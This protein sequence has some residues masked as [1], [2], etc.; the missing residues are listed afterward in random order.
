[1]S[2][3]TKILILLPNL[4]ICAELLPTKKPH[5]YSIATL[6][7]HSLEVMQKGGFNI[8]ALEKIFST[9]EKDGSYHLILSDSLFTQTIQT[10]NAESDSA[11]K[12]EIKS[13]ILPALDLSTNTHFL[14]PTVL[15]QHKG[16]TRVQLTA[17][18]K[19]LLLP[20]R[21]IA[22]KHSIDL[23]SLT[24]LSW[25]IKSMIT[26][27]PSVSVIELEGIL[28]IAQ[29]YIGVENC[30]SFNHLELK[31]AGAL[32]S[33]FKKSEPSTMSVYAISSAEVASNL[34][35]LIKLELPL[36]KMNEATQASESDEVTTCLLETIA[37]TISITDFPVP[38]LQLPKATGLEIKEYLAVNSA[39]D[40]SFKNS[41]TINQAVNDI[42]ENK[43]EIMPA[44]AN[45]DSKKEMEVVQNEESAKEEEG[46]KIKTSSSTPVVAPN[47]SE[48]L[49]KPTAVTTSISENLQSSPQNNSIANNEN[50]NSEAQP[51]INTTSIG[52]KL[53]SSSS[54]V[55][56]GIDLTQF[57]GGQLGS[58]SQQLKP[59]QNNDGGK[60]MMRMIIVMVVALVVTVSLGVGVGMYITNQA[61]KD[62]TPTP[63]VSVQPEPEIEEV[64]IDED[65]S[66]STDASESAQASGSA[67]ATTSATKANTAN[68]A[69]ASATQTDVKKSK[70]LVVNATG[71]AGLAGTVKDTLTKAGFTN[72]STGNAKGTYEEKGNFVFVKG[73]DASIVDFLEDATKLTLTLN[74]DLGKVE[75]PQGSY[76]VVIVLNE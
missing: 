5:S 41:V 14:V 64:A 36:Q 66:P 42:K 9:L 21:V 59:V 23:N 7:T 37:K 54:T 70:I 17:I 47:S 39:T 35:D 50:I 48:P 56:T 74:E 57:A 30:A 51:S 71:R 16:A 2:T 46:L 62:A 20:L 63:V 43:G 49:P 19:E 76:A 24:S 40:S 67:T 11:I 10:I 32:I 68:K 75:D 18:E 1:M 22:G 73:E 13:K 65:A 3:A 12:E 33:S 28:Y 44:Q 25:S 61:K 58:S 29:H 4:A 45:T 38:Y 72:T 53:N 27:E 6:S 31:S 60:P 15:N 52:Q 26:L 8:L 34:R 55:Q 69:T